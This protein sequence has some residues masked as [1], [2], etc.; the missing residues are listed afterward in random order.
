MNLVSSLNIEGLWGHLSFQSNFD[1]KIN[2]I[3]GTNGTGKTTIINLIAAALT[4][5]HQK[6]DKIDF[7]KIEITLKS[8]NSL[9]KPK[10]IVIKE[11]ISLSHSEIRYIF[12][13]TTKSPKFELPLGIIDNININKLY[14]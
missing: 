3:I 1:E 6:L 13:E 2:Y 14:K 10:I 7:S 9:R 11:R 8:T 12:Q 4:A 5:D